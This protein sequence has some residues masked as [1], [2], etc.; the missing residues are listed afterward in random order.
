MSNKKRITK[1]NSKKAKN[2]S[3]KKLII[4][5]SFIVCICIVITLFLLFY[6]KKKI[7]CEKKDDNGSVLIK[8][9]VQV[10]MRKKTIKEIM[11][12]KEISITKNDGK[13]DYLSAIKPSLEESYKSNNIRY[14]IEKNGDKLLINLKYNE[15][16]EYILDDLF[17]EIENDGISINLMSEDSENNYGKIN[18]SKQYQDED[19]IKILQKADYKCK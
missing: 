10:N 1:K 7:T 9:S 4:T 16:R 5:I 6:G 12:N 13:M 2:K 19:V 17:I 3:K 8:S 14:N 11:V 15:K 18:L